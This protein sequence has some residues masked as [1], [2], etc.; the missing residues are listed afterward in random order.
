ML[1]SLKK[2]L[3]LF[4]G[5]VFLICVLLLYIPGQMFSQERSLIFAS[6]TGRDNSHGIYIFEMQ[7]NE[8]HLKSKVATVKSTSYH[9]IHP[10]KPLLYAV[11][12]NKVYAF[13]INA[14]T[15]TLQYINEKESKGGPCYLSVDETGQFVLVA[16]YGGAT[17]AV[18]PLG[19]GGALQD[20]VQVLSHE[21]SSID[22]SRQ[23]S[24][25]PHMIS[26]APG[27][28]YVT[29]PD[30]GTDRIE[31]Y[32]FKSSEGTLEGHSFGKSLPGS[33]PRHLEFHPTL[34]YVF[35]LNELN[36]SVTSFKWN[37]ALGKMQHLATYPLLPDDFS[38]FNKSADIHITAN[39]K[40]LYATNRGHNSITAFEINDNGTLEL[41]DCTSV[42]GEWP[43]NFFI[44]PDDQFI[45]L[46]NRHT[47]NIVQFSIEGTTGKLKKMREYK[48]IP[49]VLCI[50]M[51]EK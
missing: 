51:F 4:P 36:S 18:Y 16:N 31:I 50:K 26:V 42:E 41:V 38:E 11:G 10:T 19:Q 29:V 28:Q 27:N 45:L 48:N 5:Y 17:I 40:F 20:P 15:A 2:L 49:G 22:T 21:G 9:N 37:S 6:S 25:H 3:N 30:L 32:R 23:Q 14:E 12:N 8:L 7:N 34:P 1:I 43:R 33:G 24:A 46:A 39:G 35:V 47:S 44:T 13:E